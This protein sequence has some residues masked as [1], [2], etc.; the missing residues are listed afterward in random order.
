MYKKIEPRFIFGG[1]ILPFR[2][3]CVTCYKTKAAQDLVFYR[4]EN[5]NG[6]ISVFCDEVCFNMWVLKNV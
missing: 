2:L 5:E 4:K 1:S 6:S 3:S